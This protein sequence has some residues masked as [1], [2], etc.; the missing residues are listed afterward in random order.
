M[1]Y[2]PFTT[3]ARLVWQSAET[4]AAHYKHEHLG[5]EH[6]LIAL[7]RSD[8]TNCWAILSELSDVRKVRLEVEKMLKLGEKDLPPVAKPRPTPKV[9]SVLLR[10]T[11]IAREQK[12]NRIGTE[13]LL[14]AL[15]AETDSIAGQA[16][17]NL[18]ITAEKVLNC[19]KELFL[20][21]ESSEIEGRMGP[22][23]VLGMS[24]L[25]L[26]TISEVVGE[27]HELPA[28]VT[29]SGKVAFQMNDVLLNQI[30]V[31]VV[32]RFQGLS[33]LCGFNLQMDE[34]LFPVVYKDA[35]GEACVIEVRRRM[36]K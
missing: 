19:K 35:I 26:N 23:A 12:R 27:G 33:L 9:K 36:S 14:L 8:K 1:M 20:T 30:C 24:Q 28:I 15:I 25:I 13:H 17:A 34:E 6:W 2:L 10:A 5:T 29:E 22:D 31:E 7:V 11:Q 4:E 21:D 18:D 32:K 16:L 3:P